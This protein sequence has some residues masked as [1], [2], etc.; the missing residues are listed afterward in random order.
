MG[1][2]LRFIGLT[3]FFASIFALV[4]TDPA[5]ALADDFVVAMAALVVALAEAFLTGADFGMK[6]A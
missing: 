5:F 1:T 2:A 6:G 4:L 3:T